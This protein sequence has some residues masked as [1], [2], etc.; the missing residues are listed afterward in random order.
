MGVDVRLA[1]LADAPAATELLRRSISK[2]CVADH[3]D[4]PALLQAW[5]ENKTVSNVATWIGS[6]NNYCV[7]ASMDEAICG[8]GAMTTE[9]E[10]MLC[11]VEPAVR[12]RGVSAA[13]LEA[14]EHRAQTLGLPAVRLDATTTAS[15]FYLDRGYNC[16][17]ERGKAF[18][19][20]ACRSMVKRFA[21]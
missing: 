5:L 17:D 21:L 2:L 16:A 6:A 14:L 20:I 12:F 18:G 4:D 7:V 11:Y 3:H 10:I 1:V 19:T 13:I 9:G 15:R 8:F